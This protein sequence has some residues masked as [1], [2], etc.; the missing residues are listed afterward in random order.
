MTKVEE[1]KIEEIEEKHDL[2]D[3]EVSGKVVHP[4]HHK[5]KLK[6]IV[7]NEV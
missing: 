2:C 1:G 5:C 7:D 6:E 4:E 3:P